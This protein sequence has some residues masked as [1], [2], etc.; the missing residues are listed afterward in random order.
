MPDL[1]L[2]RQ[3]YALNVTSQNGA[4]I[5]EPIIDMLEAINNNGG[6]V[7]GITDGNDIYTYE[8][9]MTPDE[10]YQYFTNGTGL[11]DKIPEK[12]SERKKGMTSR[13]IYRQL[14][15][16]SNTLSKIIGTK[17]TAEGVTGNGVN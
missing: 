4:E 17:E 13:S 9:F 6:N 10:V 11:I 8:D 1:D 2:S 16:L 15:I 3:L 7:Y 12:A 5:R 14:I